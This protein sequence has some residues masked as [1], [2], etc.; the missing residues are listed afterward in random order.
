MLLPTTLAMAAAAAILNMWLIIR[1]GRLRTSEK[2]MHGDGGNALLARRM[3]AQANF[4]E[5]VPIVLILIAAI[6][7]SGSGG[8]WL[9]IVGGI[10]MLGR[11]AHVLGMDS[12]KPNPLRATG[13]IVTMLVLLGL[14]LV[15]VLIT[16]GRF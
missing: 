2:I 4:V 3:R 7:L 14:A 16:L 8:R 15:A 1:I 12:D 13:A 9:G 10:F 5:N 6:E 11:V